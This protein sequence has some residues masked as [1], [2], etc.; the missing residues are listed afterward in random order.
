MLN[1]LEE[2]GLKQGRDFTI[3]GCGNHPFSEVLDFCS[4]D[5]NPSLVGRILRGFLDEYYKRGAIE[6]SEFNVPLG[7][8]LRSYAGPK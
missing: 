8:V 1:H 7:L 5:F 3:I 2:I 4:L 6:A